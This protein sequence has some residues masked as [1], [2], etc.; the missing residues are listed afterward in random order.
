VYKTPDGR[1][2]PAEQVAFEEDGRPYTYEWFDGDETFEAPLQAEMET[3]EDAQAV[4]D[5]S[6][7][8]TYA[9]VDPE[10]EA[11][12]CLEGNYEDDYKQINRLEP[13]RDVWRPM[14]YR[15]FTV[16][17]QDTIACAC[18][19]FTPK[20]GKKGQPLKSGTWT[21]DAM[22]RF[23]AGR[24]KYKSEPR[25]ET[26]RRWARLQPFKASKDQLIRY[27]EWK[28]HKVPQNRKTHKPTTAAKEIDRL[29]KKTGDSLYI[30]TLVGRAVNKVDSTYTLG[31]APWDDGR[32][33]SEFAYGPASG[34][35]NSR[36]PNVQN[37]PKHIRYE[38]LRPLN[39]PKKFRRLIKASPGHS[40]VECV[41]PDTR[42]LRSSLTWDKA[43]NVNVGDRVIGFDEHLQTRG[44]S[45]RP[46]RYLRHTYILS[47]K[48]IE[49]ECVRIITTRGEM[50]CSVDHGFVARRGSTMGQK[51]QRAD[52]LKKGDR[53]E[54]F[55]EPWETDETRQ[56]GYLAGFLDG[57]GCTDR[58]LSFGQ[59]EGIVAAFAQ[60][61]LNK[62]GFKCARR[63]THRD[64]KYFEVLGSFEWLRAIGTLRP[65]RLLQKAQQDLD[66]MAYWGKGST[67]AIVLAVIPVGK[68]TVIAFETT[69]HTFIAEG[70]LS[71]NCDYKSFHILTLGFNAKDATYM[72]MARLDMHTYFSSHMLC[73]RG[74]IKEPI[75]Q[76][77]PDAD[78]KAALKDLKGASFIPLGGTW[79]RLTKDLEKAYAG[80]TDI[81]VVKQLR[82]QQAKPAILGKGLGMSAFRLYQENIE[83]FSSQSV[84]EGVMATYDK[85]FP[86]VIEYQKNIALQAHDQKYLT[87]LHG[88]IRRFWDVFSFLYHDDGTYETKHGEDYEAAAAFRVQ[89][90]AFGHIRDVMIMLQEEGLNEAVIPVV[91]P[92]APK[93]IGYPSWMRPDPI[94]KPQNFINWVRL[95]RLINTV[96][97][98]LVFEMD[99]DHLQTCVRH[100]KEI[101]ERKS[102]ILVNEV[103]PEG[104]WCEVEV[105]A[106]PDWGS[107]KEL[108]L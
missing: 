105:S 14:V 42:M 27:M 78:L 3:A 80:A 5:G 70:F 102:K 26:V 48:Y 76:H 84:A 47:K 97:D 24:G 63:E 4:L 104:L 69:T 87:S 51:W 11:M 50:T 85:T 22:C 19:V 6:L 94:V 66:G 90:D 82:D 96:H 38:R 41:V 29:A 79:Q 73:A 58:S 35:L 49:K 15:T 65:L 100:I 28:G 23:C 44:Q 60:D 71:H 92:S 68:Q 99:N 20:L 45:K 53:I 75:D 43:R 86:K 57:E 31:W 88:F 25:T 37:P 2:V 33:H 67:P 17:V 91:L 21:T 9:H 16:E 98:S 39:L 10:A 72:R 61:L 74:V 32:V 13:T 107:M 34:Q 103:A 77:L 59:N 36:R 62:N 56:G 55:K 8:P 101:M 108:P 52:W 93:T 106:G 7:D 64:C 83:Y 81:I 40:I 1:T 18:R 46:G 89:N 30:N 12:A 95:A 54:F